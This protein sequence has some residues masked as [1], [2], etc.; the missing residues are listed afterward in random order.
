M[1]SAYLIVYEYVDAAVVQQPLC[2]KRGGGRAGRK[3]GM[4]ED[5]RKGWECLFAGRVGARGLVP[6]VLMKALHL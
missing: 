4:K 2:R 6:G 3:E 5:N 1:P